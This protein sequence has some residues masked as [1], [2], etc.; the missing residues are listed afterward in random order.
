M[1]PKSQ[2]KKMENSSS[3]EETSKEYSDPGSNLTTKNCLLCDVELEPQ[4]QETREMRF[5][6]RKMLDCLCLFLNLEVPQDK[7][8]DFE[9]DNFPF[10]PSCTEYLQYLNVFYD[11]LEVVHT[12]VSQVVNKIKRKFAK[13]VRRRTNT[14]FSVGS[15]KRE[16]EELKRPRDSRTR[17]FRNLIEITAEDYSPHEESPLPELKPSDMMANHSNSCEVAEAKLDIRREDKESQT[18][19]TIVIE[20][21]EAKLDIRREDKESQTQQII[22]IEDKECQTVEADEKPSQKDKEKLSVTTQTEIVDT[23]YSTSDVEELDEC[24]ADQLQLLNSGTDIED[25]NNEL[26]MKVTLT[27]YSGDDDNQPN[28]SDDEIKVTEVPKVSA[29]SHIELAASIKSSEV[30][31]DSAPTTSLVLPV[32]PVPACENNDR[33]TKLVL[34]PK[35]SWSIVRTEAGFKYGNIETRSKGSTHICC[36]CDQTVRYRSQE[37][38]LDHLESEHLGKDHWY[39]CHYCEETFRLVGQLHKHV[40]AF[41][42]GK[43]DKGWNFLCP[44]CHKRFFSAELFQ[45]HLRIHGINETE[46]NINSRAGLASGEM[47]LVTTDVVEIGSSSDSEP[48]VKKSLRPRTLQRSKAIALSP[49]PEVEETS[50]VVLTDSV[51]EELTSSDSDIGKK[52]RKMSRH[53]KQKRPV[54][55]IQS[56]PVNVTTIEEISLSQ[57]LLC[58]GCGCRYFTESEAMIKTIKEHYGHHKQQRALA[59]RI[60]FQCFTSLPEMTSHVRHHFNS[61]GYDNYMFY[62]PTDAPESTTTCSTNQSIESPAPVGFQGSE[63]LA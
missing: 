4:N 43:P 15:P 39:P 36:L 33:Y 38:L 23:N 24:A 45:R 19:E 27:E 12:K 18:Q 6:Y 55:P 32:Q 62:C 61:G 63:D 7:N 34:V 8:W 29:G 57:R 13:T 5:A 42:F 28:K 22:A 21:N 3:N 53:R 1:P 47:A 35:P 59:C 31:V 11:Q 37:K 40:R 52:R 25:G 20:D 9:N 60:C 17:S 16:R 2:P 54:K 50:D 46:S 14:S 44:V 48:S 26:T 58:G 10:C 30:S 51:S 41:H 56:S 49:E